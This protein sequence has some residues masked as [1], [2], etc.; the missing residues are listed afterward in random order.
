MQ[1]PLLPPPLRQQIL[2][3]LGKISTSWRWLMFSSSNEPHFN[4]TTST[5]TLR[6]KHRPNL[7][8]FQMTWKKVIFH[9]H[10]FL[11]SSSCANVKILSGRIS[12]CSSPMEEYSF[13][14]RKSQVYSNPN[15]IRHF[16]SKFTIHGSAPAKSSKNIFQL[17]PLKVFSSFSLE[18]S[19]CNRGAHPTA[20]IRD[21]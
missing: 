11:C 3:L 17:G 16:H 13:L 19:T 18:G 2:A 21:S 7:R 10:Q 6:E 15:S 9:V 1:L 12:P 20:H 14:F 5:M 8:I 4:S